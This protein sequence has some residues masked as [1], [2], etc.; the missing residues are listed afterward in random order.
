MLRSDLNTLQGQAWLN[1][2]VITIMFSIFQDLMDDIVLLWVPTRMSRL[3]GKPKIDPNIHN[4]L[5]IS[6]QSILLLAI[7]DRQESGGGDMLGSTGVC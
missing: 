5:Q 3:L 6:L 1:D 2:A 7:N 4:D